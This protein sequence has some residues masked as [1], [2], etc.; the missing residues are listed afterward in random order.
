[1]ATT[2]KNQWSILNNIQDT[3]L[4]T[5]IEV[6]LID[7]KAQ[8]FSPGT[9]YFYQKKLVL[10]ADFCSSKLITQITQITPRTC[11]NTCFN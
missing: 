7:R 1:M 3:H 11:E 8:G 4:L 2:T 10:F 9:L 5:W 6:F